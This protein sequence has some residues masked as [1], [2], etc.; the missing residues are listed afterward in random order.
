M[1]PRLRRIL[2]PLI[3]LCTAFC[4]HD[5][6]DREYLTALRGEE[7]DMTREE[8]IAHIDRAIEI[9]S[10]RARYWEARAIYRIDLHQFDAALAD[11]DRAVKLAESPYIRFLR[12]LALCQSGR[13]AESLADFDAAIAGQPENAQFYRGRALARVEVGMAA[14]ALADAD[15]LVALAPQQAASHYARGRS[16]AALGRDREALA[17]YDEAI[18]QR[19]EL[20]YPLRARADSLERLGETTRAAA[21]RSAA[22]SSAG[23]REA[24][25]VC[26]DPF[27]Y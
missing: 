22:E 15:H 12:G 14:D 9:S 18:R 19:P 27:R 1:H 5:E 6:A 10:T 25:A 23:E 24:C 17:Q 3:L 26:L 8:Q 13:H 11:L 20:V 21:D 4:G 2:G 7:E 16:L